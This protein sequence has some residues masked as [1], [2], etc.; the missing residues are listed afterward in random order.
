MT[1]PAYFDIQNDVED[2]YESN[3]NEQ[4]DSLRTSKR[5]RQSLLVEPLCDPD[6]YNEFTDLFPVPSEEMAIYESFLKHKSAQWS[7]LHTNMSTDKMQWEAKKTVVINGARTEVDLITPDEKYYL[8][9]TLAY[10]L[11]G[12][13][14]VN[15]NEKSKLS[16]IT[17]PWYKIFLNDK[18]DREDVHNL[19]YNLM[20]EGLISSPSERRE[21]RE[22]IKN[23]PVIQEKIQWLRRYIKCDSLAHKELGSCITEGIFFSSSFASIYFF[24]KERDGILPGI[25]SYNEYISLDEKMHVEMAALIYRTRVVNK[26]PREELIEM[27]EKAVDIETR[28]ATQGLPCNLIGLK[29]EHMHTYIRYCAD[30]IFMLLTGEEEGI[31]N[32]ENPFDFM[33]F[34]S[35]N[36]VAD[37]FSHRVNTYSETVSSGES[38]FACDIDF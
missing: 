31:Y 7:H 24:K 19:S 20:I 17:N 26:L 12:D 35:V 6:K 4:Q 2:L 32:V 14:E 33:S 37:F 8:K 15:D 1:T 36:I 22:T 27:I 29:K 25:S 21:V 9:N 38:N 34:M 13:F 16:T 3:K 23:S 30:W 11:V 5:Q 18:V 28:F 10:F